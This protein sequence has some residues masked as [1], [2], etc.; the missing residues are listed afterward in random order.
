MILQN[1]FP[2]GA[3]IGG[4]VNH[5]LLERRLSLSL[6]SKRIGSEQW[7]RKPEEWYSLTSFNNPYQ[8]IYSE[9]RLL[10][11]YSG[12]ISRAIG[13]SAL[14]FYGVGTGDTEAVFARWMLETYGYAEVIAIDAIRPFLERFAFIL[15][16]LRRQKDGSIVAFAGLQ[17][18]FEQ[19][20]RDMILPENSVFGSNAHVCLGNTVGNF[21]QREI[22]NIFQRLVKKD[23]LLVLGVHLSSN[24]KKTL[25]FYSNPLVSRFVFSSIKHRFPGKSIASIRWLA[26]EEEHSIEA[27]LGDIN[28][29]RS[30]KYAAGEISET[31]KKHRFALEQE[32]NDKNAAIVLLRKR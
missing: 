21:E 10:E 27:W 14:V 1:L 7:Y 20:S 16:N 19:L 31:A 13:K 2:G 26:N 29:F 9:L 25:K 5:R 22:F 15:S 17:T 18:L 4:K 6:K 11:K 30:R 23:E 12:Q 8:T 3:L 28:V 24:L 32:C